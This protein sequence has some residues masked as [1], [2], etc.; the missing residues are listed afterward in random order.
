MSRIPFGYRLEDKRL[1]LGDA[2]RVETVRTIFESY[3]GGNSMRA[4]AGMLHRERRLTSRG[5]AWA[6]STVEAVLGNVVYK[7]HF[8]GTV[9]TERST[10]VSRRVR[11]TAINGLSLK[12]TIRPSCQANCSS[13]WRSGGGSVAA[14][15]RLTATARGSCLPAWPNAAV[16]AA[17]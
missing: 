8:C 1:V 16:A 3:A 9:R 12:T 13:K 7:E 17:R 14:D 10:V 6:A 11:M 5:G 4:I 15:Q 2:D